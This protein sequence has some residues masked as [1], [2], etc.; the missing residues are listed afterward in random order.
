MNT[1]L[2]QLRR[3]D[4]ALI[5]SILFITLIGLLS[6][7]S[8]GAQDNHFFFKRQVLWVAIGLLTMGIVSFFD[9]RLWRTASFAVMLFYLAATALLIVLLVVAPRIRGITAWFRF[10]SV[11]FA[12]V[13]LMKI[14]VIILLAK[15]FSQRHVDLYRLRHLVISGV[16]VGI[17]AFLVLLQPDFG[18]L[19]A[20]AGVWCT[21]ILLAGIRRREFFILLAG[22]AFLATSLWTFALHDYQRTRV[23]VFLNPREDPLGSGY[24]AI[25]AQIAVGAGGLRGSGLGQGSQVQ[26]RFL[27]EAKTDF[28]FAAVAEEWG[29]L[30]VVGL[31]G[32]CA[33][34]FW[35]MMQ[36]GLRAGN[37]FAR[38]YVGGLVASL[39]LNVVIH[40]GMNMGLFPI[41]GIPFPFLSYGG[42]S[43]L[44]YFLAVGVLQNIYLHTRLQVKEE[45]FD[46]E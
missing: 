30:G 44:A 23:L 14:A 4:W 12:P 41:T 35:R 25:Q 9:Y 33:Y 34:M 13:E 29:F 43:M 1:V 24:Q 36:T 38:L 20:L 8:I 32:A 10:G 28:M 11:N 46:A 27:P 22:G 39:F 15:Y 42:S 19:I 16:Y 3:L 37:N 7:Y 26:Y 18:S 40:T 2:L 6:L 5:A 21:V 17:P 45:Q 31:L